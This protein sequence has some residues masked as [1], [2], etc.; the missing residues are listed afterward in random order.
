MEASQ[1]LF[2]AETMK[3]KFETNR[4]YNQKL[5]NANEAQ[6]EILKEQSTSS[7]GIEETYKKIAMVSKEIDVVDEQIKQG[8]KILVD[9]LYKPKPRL[10]EC[11]DTLK[12][13][14]ISHNYNMMELCKEALAQQKVEVSI[15]KMI[16]YESQ[17]SNLISNLRENELFQQSQSEELIYKQRLENHN[18]KLLSFIREMETINRK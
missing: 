11:S 10:N 6:L 4:I 18:S 17:I 16:E 1:I 15:L 8:S 13:I 7:S 2:F 5:T 9:L 14:L 3:D 12:A